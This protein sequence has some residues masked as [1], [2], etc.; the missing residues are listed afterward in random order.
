[1]TRE[2][3][4]AWKA[5]MGQLANKSE[6]VRLRVVERACL[7]YFGGAASTWA[8]ADERALAEEA[9]IGTQKELVA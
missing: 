8:E 4:A 5:L 3:G 9:G 6:A 7:I 2:E 1:M